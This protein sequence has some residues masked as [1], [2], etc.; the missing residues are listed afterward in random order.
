M[1]AYNII[2]NMVIEEDS[3]VKIT[4]KPHTITENNELVEICL[5]SKIFAG[6]IDFFLGFDTEIVNPVKDGFNDM[7]ISKNFGVIYRDYLGSNKWYSINEVNIRSNREY[8]LDFRLKFKQKVNGKYNVCLKPSRET[9][10]SAISKNQFYCLDPWFTLDGGTCNN[11]YDDYYPITTIDNYANPFLVN[12]TFGVDFG[13]G[14]Q[15]IWCNATSNRLC[16]NSSSDYACFRDDNKMPTYIH[17]GNGEN[18]LNSLSTDKNLILWLHLN[19]TDGHDSSAYENQKVSETGSIYAVDGKIENGVQFF[20]DGSSINYGDIDSFDGV[21]NLTL[22]VWVKIISDETGCIVCKSNQ[23]GDATDSIYWH[24]DQNKDKF[25]FHYRDSDS[26]EGHDSTSTVSL[27]T[28]YHVAVTYA[29]GTLTYYLN[30][31]EDGSDSSGSGA[32]NPTSN[33]VTLG[34]VNN[35]QPTTVSDLRGIIDEVMVFNR[36]L[37]DEEIL[38]IYNNTKGDIYAP[39]GMINFGLIINATVHAPENTTYIGTTRELLVSANGSVHTW[40]YSLNDGANITFTPNTT[41]ES[42]E[43]NNKLVVY[44]NSTFGDENSTTIYFYVDHVPTHTKPVLISESGKNSTSDDLTCLNQSTFDYEGEPV[45]NIFNWLIDNESI[46]E[47]FLPFE[48][49]SNS[50]YTKDYSGKNRHGTVYNGNWTD[51]SGFD[52]RGSYYFNQ[53]NSEHI[54]V[55]DLN[56]TGNFTLVI[57]LNK[58]EN[59]V[60]VIDYFFSWGQ[61]LTPNSLN[62]LFN[63]ADNIV[64][65]FYSQTGSIS[66]TI[67]FS[68]FDQWV[69]YALVVDRTS[70]ISIYLDGVLQTSLGSGFSIF[71]PNTDIHLGGREDDDPDRYYTGWLDEVQIYDRVLTQEQ[72]N[73]LYINN[74]DTLLSEQTEL[75]NNYYC[76]ITPNDGLQDGIELKSNKLRVSCEFDIN[77]ISPQNILYNTTNIS[78]IVSR[79]D[80]T[81]TTWHYILNGNDSTLFTP[82]TTITAREFD[83]T[84]T[85]LAEDTDECI[86]QKTVN[87]RVELI[88]PDILYCKDDYLYRRA[89]EK[90]ILNGI[91]DIETVETLLLCDNGCSDS[92]LTNW[93]E[94]G[95][96]ENDY[97]LAIYLFI[98]I[99][100]IALIVWVI[101]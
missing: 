58:K 99:G 83:N 2:D 39:I 43:G 82:N 90:T 21:N 51:N 70:G 73:A 30:G 60:Q 65:Y 29:S 38:A 68:D 50:T 57:W 32:I 77:I 24:Y 74:Y 25:N 28:W 61:V 16:Y 49:G 34:W 97:V 20:S 92:T 85:I 69:Q 95:C 55:P 26:W 100:L 6:D 12:D 78:L 10:A 44:A 86:S 4:A 15:Y 1:S 27:N 88:P 47:L 54:V 59:T 66:V 35:G 98:I 94:P 96:I 3:R 79:E 56:L 17:H 76:N 84:L 19:G 33:S 5:T 48:G 63:S 11:E 36:T 53:N 18:Y 13:D 72:L 52:N 42:I 64:T 67:G 75:D 46:L 45:K 14:V 41:F 37:S 22:L 81:T 89:S 91:E 93:G 40:W 87:F 7:I 62:I 9:F 71:N 101:K 31:I 8:C 80:N 23:Y